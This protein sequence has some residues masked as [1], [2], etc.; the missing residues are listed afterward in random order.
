MKWGV[1]LTTF[2]LTWFLVPDVHAQE[3]VSFEL[4]LSKEKLGINERLRAEF[5]MN[6]DGDNFTPPAFDGFKVVMGPSQSIKSSWI[7]GKRTF[8]KT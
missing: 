6:K 5:T 7:N 1:F 4:K 3:E 8:S 2:F